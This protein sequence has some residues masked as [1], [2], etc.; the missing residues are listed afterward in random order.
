[1]E[2]FQSVEGIQSSQQES[3]NEQQLDRSCP[4]K[5]KIIRA[6]SHLCPAQMKVLCLGFAR[7]CFPPLSEPA[8]QPGLHYWWSNGEQTPWG[9]FISLSLCLQSMPASSSLRNFGSSCCTQP[10]AV[11]NFIGQERHS[12][13]IVLTE[14][15]LQG[16]R[17][18]CVVLAWAGYHFPGMII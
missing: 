3:T 1:M 14:K 16:K 10:L 13:Q 6:V 11:G 7:D 4:F 9:I 8:P 15:L 2:S 5:I 12:Q 18:T 17:H